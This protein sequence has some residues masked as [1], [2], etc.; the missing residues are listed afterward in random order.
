VCHRFIHFAPPRLDGIDAADVRRYGAV[1]ERFYA[2]Q[3]ELLGELLAAM[4]PGTV[5]IV[6]SDHGFTSGPERPAGR[7]ADIEGQPARWHRRHGMLALAGPAVREGPI[8]TASLLDV[9][10]T[11]L[12]LAGLP[13]PRSMSG[14]V[15]ASAIDPGFT[16][17]HPE[18]RL[19]DA[20]L[21]PLRSW[22][23]GNP[24]DAG[25]PAGG[26][27]D[28]G[29]QEMMA[30]LRSLGYIGGGA[31]TIAPRPAPAAA[32]GGATP[33]VPDTVTAHANMAGILMSSGDLAR[34]EP[35]VMA[36]MRLAPL[37]LQARQ[38]LFD[39]RMRQRRFA[40]ALAVGEG[41]LE[42]DP[43]LLGETF[44]ARLA[45]AYSEA[46]EV[47]RGTARFERE[48][49]RGR[50]RMGSA[51]ARLHKEAGRP[52]AAAVVARA[53]LA[54]DP[55]DESSMA[56]LVGLSQPRGL[57]TLEPI[58]ADALRRNPRSVMHLNWMALCR[59][60]AGDTE[61]ALRLMERALDV[62]PDHPATLANLGAIHLK[63]GRADLAIP[64]L[65]RAVDLNPASVEAQVNLGTAW[66]LQQRY[67]EAIQQFESVWKQ[68]YRNPAISQALSR[69]W[70]G[71]GDRAAARHW[72][73]EAASQKH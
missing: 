36:A 32:G 46:G 60:D 8:D 62:N 17:S 33:Q 39:L 42:A 26:A 65:V 35:E 37:S 43:E 61:N 7:T 24:R 4:D 30:T 55:L 10:P 54:H 40:E 59:Q 38:L 21:P 22:A 41:M 45:G 73:E 5:V 34:A 49:G 51:L 15:L 48:I 2:W 13:V 50:W 53:V 72:Q 14:K 6:I 25:A 52:E 12:Y 11:V 19:S 20:E 56:V 71:L 63:S 28:P 3:D 70:L 64:V 1:V 68:G 9:A 66:A 57:A 69:A 67:H 47:A 27:G 58:L 29:A 31:D 18:R 16:A 44:P 23:Q